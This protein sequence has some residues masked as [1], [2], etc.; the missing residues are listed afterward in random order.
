MTPQPDA[1]RTL[2]ER[3]YTMRTGRNWSLRQLGEAA[4]GI[5]KGHLSE[6]ENGNMQPGIDIVNR[7]AQAFDISPAVLVGG[8]DSELAPDEQALIDA[9]RAGDKLAAITIVMEK[10]PPSTAGE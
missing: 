7:I 6:I 3:I 4:G 5:S 8:Q 1:V 2:G 10:Q 9:Y